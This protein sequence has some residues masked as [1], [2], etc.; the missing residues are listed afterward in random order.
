MALGAWPVLK[1]IFIEVDWTDDS[2][3]GPF[4]SHRP[5]VEAVGMIEAAFAAAPVPNPYNAPDGVRLHIDYGQGG[6]FRGGNY[7]PGSPEYIVFDS[8]FNELKAIH[9]DRN[10]KGFFHYAI[11]T[12]R[13]T[14]AQ[15]DSSGVAEIDGDDFMVTLQIYLSDRNVSHTTMHELGHNMNLRH[16]GFEDLNY[17]PNYNSIMNYRFQF[18]GVDDDCDAIG[19]GVL[20]Y[21]V[22]ARLDLD[23][24]HL[25]EF[26]G[27]CGNVPIDWDGGGLQAD[28]AQN[29]NCVAGVTSACGSQHGSCWDRSCGFLR[30]FDDWSNVVFDTLKGGDFGPEIVT[31][32]DVPTN[33]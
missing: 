24:N 17:K 4:H 30:T 3:D 9:F 10:R 5:T 13:H 33:P 23:E 11:F 16:G 2:H 6:P 31:C 25:N 1:D 26:E 19:D 28:V 20:D 7:I 14:D 12:H 18:F 29:I 27:V 8:E 22:A 15:N 21:S 32:K